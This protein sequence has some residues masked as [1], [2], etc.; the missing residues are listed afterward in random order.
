MTITANS[1]LPNR[2]PQTLESINNH[3]ANNLLATLGA[4]LVYVQDGTGRYLSFYW[5]KSDLLGFNPEQIVADGNSQ[6]VFAP[7]DKIS[8]MER[9]HQVMTNSVPEKFPFWFSC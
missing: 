6:E 7:V 4:E 3:K 2:F 9:L 5:Q 8:Y 1:Q